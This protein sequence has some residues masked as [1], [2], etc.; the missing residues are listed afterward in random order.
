[1]TLVSDAARQAG[2]PMPFLSTLVDRYTSAKARGR[3]DFDW[4]AIGLS[5]AEDA[6]ID[7]SARCCSHPKG[8]RRGQYVLACLLSNYI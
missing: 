8:R 6:G 7:V 1:M 2:A 4:S 5:I 3:G